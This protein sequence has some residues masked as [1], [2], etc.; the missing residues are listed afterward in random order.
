[1]ET[2]CNVS[3]QPC[4]KIN[5]EKPLRQTMGEAA[6]HKRDHWLREALTG[7]VKYFSFTTFAAGKINERKCSNRQESGPC[8]FW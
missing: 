5:G 4:K 2:P 6:P 1:M 3:N 7:D 8:T